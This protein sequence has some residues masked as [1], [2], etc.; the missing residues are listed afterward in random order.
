MENCKKE[1]VEA[2]QLMEKL[3]YVLFHE[4]KPYEIDNL[5]YASRTLTR[6]SYNDGLINKVV[7]YEKQ[8]TN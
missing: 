7:D 3:Q 4:L 2:V 5:R 1:I 8:K 6:L